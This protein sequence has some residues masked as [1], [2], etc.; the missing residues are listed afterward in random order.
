MWKL[1]RK[2]IAEAGY[3]ELSKAFESACALATVL[4]PDEFGVGARFSS[5]SFQFS[6]CFVLIRLL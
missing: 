6:D 1:C 3:P 4:G 5:G 2:V